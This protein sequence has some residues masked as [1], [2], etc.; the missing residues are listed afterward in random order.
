M[1]D[2]II[3]LLAHLKG[4]KVMLPR[5][6]GYASFKQQYNTFFYHLLP[7]DLVRENM[8]Q[9]LRNPVCCDTY[10]GIDQAGSHII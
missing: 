1:Y 6:T 5:I 8:C 3:E 2:Q 7:F 4:Y 10:K 9:R